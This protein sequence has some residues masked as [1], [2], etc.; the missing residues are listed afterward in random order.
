MLCGSLDG[1]SGLGRMKVKVSCSALL[2]V[3]DST[4]CSLPGCSSME[5]SRQKYPSGLWI[6]VYVL[7]SP[8]VVH[9]KTF[10][11]LLIRYIPI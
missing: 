10:T 7:L 6:H 5:F 2:T 11:T 8:F 4:V 1:S 9:L 3:R